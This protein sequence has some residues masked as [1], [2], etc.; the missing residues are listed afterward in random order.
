M[1]TSLVYDE[2]FVVTKREEYKTIVTFRSTKYNHTYK[3]HYSLMTIL[4]CLL[5]GDHTWLGVYAAISRKLIY[6]TYTASEIS[7]ELTQK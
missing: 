4:A 1:D 2:N 3:A 7:Y 5:H 6:K